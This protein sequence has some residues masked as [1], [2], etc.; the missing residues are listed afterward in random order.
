MAGC[1]SWWRCTSASQDETGKASSQG[2]SNG[3]PAGSRPA[4]TQTPTAGPR[5]CG[6]MASDFVLIS[7]GT[8]AHWDVSDDGTVFS[9]ESADSQTSG[10]FCSITLLRQSD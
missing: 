3:S 8:L 9:P 7:T 2:A 5:Q 6:K 10:R 1:C 4:I